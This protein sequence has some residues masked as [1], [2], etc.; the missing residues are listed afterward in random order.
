MLCYFEQT[1]VVAPLM[2]NN[3]MCSALSSTQIRVTWSPPS[4]RNGV[5]RHYE[6]VLHDINTTQTVTQFINGQTTTGTISHLQPNHHYS[7]SVTA[8]N[9][10]TVRGELTS[11]ATPIVTREDGTC[12]IIDII[13]WL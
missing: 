10:A 5:I 11:T 13:L 1:V 9:T 12:S 4:H 7:C 3:L 6:M 2:V 8:H